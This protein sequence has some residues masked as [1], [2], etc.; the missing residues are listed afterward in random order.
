M[1]FDNKQ[2][3]V[4]YDAY[5][6]VNSQVFDADVLIE[7]PTEEKFLFSDCVVIF[8]I[9]DNTNTRRYFEFNYFK[10]FSDKELNETA[11]KGRN[12]F[13]VYLFF[14]DKS[15]LESFKTTNQFII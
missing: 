6:S 15:F 5:V 8:F 9:V 10:T 4:P 11:F 12:P 3:K 7:L 1:I 2:F 13:G 14:K